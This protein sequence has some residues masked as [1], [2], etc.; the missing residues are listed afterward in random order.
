MDNA[1][2]NGQLVHEDVLCPKP[3]WIDRDIPLER[4]FTAEKVNRILNHPSVYDWVRGEW[5][6]PMDLALVMK[7]TSVVLLGE[8]GG[9]SF[10]KQQAGLY[11]AHTWVLPEGRGRW[12]IQMGRAALRYMFFRTD[13]IEI[14]TKVP[15]GN[16]AAHAGARAIGA[17]F[18]FTHDFGFPLM[19]KKVPVDIYS[20]RLWEWLAKAPWL[21]ERGKW[22]H[23]TLA[24]ESD[25]KGLAIKEHKPDPIHDRYVGLATE[26][27]LAGQVYKAAAFYN[28]WA[29]C[30]MAPRMVIESMDPVVL[31]FT[32]FRIRLTD[33]SYEVLPCQSQ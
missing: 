2:M 3:I 19:G 27:I 5:E 6:G 4:Q 20:L 10:H 17:S 18:D 21:V 24:Y 28:R 12:T 23:D 26:M 14:V 25:A 31:N 16:L 15:H 29:A 9:C 7:P 30:V 1:R 32:E 13:A 8:H 11:E 33:G 22:F